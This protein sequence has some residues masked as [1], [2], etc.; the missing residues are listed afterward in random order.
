MREIVLDTETT[1]LDP[2]R[3]DRLIEIA[4]LE[5]IDRSPT[6]RTFHVYINPERDVPAEAFAIHG[7][8]TA[9]LKDKPLFADIADDFLAFV[10]GAQLV[11]H[12]AAFDTG[13]LNAELEKTGRPA[14]FRERIVDTLLLARRRWP[15]GPNNLDALCDRF[16]ID[17]TKRDK[18]GAMVDVELLAEIYIELIGG[19]QTAFGLDPVARPGAGPASNRAR[20]A[21][22]P[23]PLPARLDAQTRTAHREFVATLTK[24]E[25]LWAAYL[26]G[27]TDP[28]KPVS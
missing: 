18:H 24:A 14:L 10:D 7:I 8:S 17:R 26:A 4:G 1:G 19:R 2:F 9:F 12:N 25:P 27:E 15:A 3:G 11:I 20:L 22:R 28:D 23:A 6:G 13:F 21:A 16:G 5:M